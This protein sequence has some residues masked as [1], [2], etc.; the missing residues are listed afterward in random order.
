[1]TAE[2]GVNAGRSCNQRRE[3]RE[4]SVVGGG[5]KRQSRAGEE[6]RGEANSLPFNDLIYF[7]SLFLAS[8][9]DA[10]LFC[11]SL[12]CLSLSSFTLQRQTQAADG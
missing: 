5:G 2:A 12:H 9:S 3:A 7:H 10:L 6:C 4:G 8:L 11:I 1:M